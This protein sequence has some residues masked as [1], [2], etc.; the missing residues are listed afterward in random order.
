M[1]NVTKVGDATCMR[2]WLKKRRK[3]RILTLA[4]SQWLVPWLL[5]VRNPHRGTGGCGGDGGDPDPFCPRGL[6]FPSKQLCGRH[7]WAQVGWSVQPLNDRKLASGCLLSTPVVRC[8]CVCMCVCVCVYALG[9]NSQTFRWR[10]QDAILLL[11][12]MTGAHAAHFYNTQV[13]RSSA[14]IRINLIRPVCKGRKASW[15]LL[16]MIWTWR[17]VPRPLISKLKER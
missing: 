15:V 12:L 5:N 11:M 7:L 8:V 3:K 9:L 1:A 6:T 10:A 14:T 17:S 13:S 16:W 2:R 4:Q